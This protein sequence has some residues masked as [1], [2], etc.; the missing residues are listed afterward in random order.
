MIYH[1]I[2]CC[3]LL[4]QRVAKKGMEFYDFENQYMKLQ[5]IY[6][7][8]KLIILEFKQATTKAEVGNNSFKNETVMFGMCKKRLKT[9][10]LQSKHFVFNFSLKEAVLIFPMITACSSINLRG[11]TRMDSKL[12]QK[13]VWSNPDD[14]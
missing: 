6:A 7:K 4:A 12:H 2:K 11:C 5:C 8:N 13:V 9:V 1:S 3:G 10:F 14:N